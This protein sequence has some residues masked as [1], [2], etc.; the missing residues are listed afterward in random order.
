MVSS[1]HEAA[2][3]IFQDRPELLAPVFRI[4]DLPPPEKAA[5][6]VL[7]PDA[8][9]IRPLERRVDSVLRVNPLEGDGF[10]LAIE[11]QGRRDDAKGGSW[12]Y[13]LSYLTAKYERPALLLVVCQD[14]ATADWAM[15]PFQLGLDDWTALSVHPLVLGPGNVPVILD[16]EEAAQDLTL[17]TFSALTHGSH[18]EAPAILKALARA[19]GTADPESVSYYSELLEI[20]LGG[21]PA[22]ITWRNEMSVGTYFPGRGTLIEET[23]LKGKAEGEARGVLRV[24]EKRGIPTLAETRDRIINCTDLDTLDRWLDRAVTVSTADELFAEEEP[25]R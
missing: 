10:L 13:Y 11:A 9:E 6:E 1:R 17:A 7:T 19:M 4:L 18:R 16:P 20:G 14:K 3:R 5:V 23:F 15:G 21:T 22:G 12:A 25:G 24:L 8:T 2:H